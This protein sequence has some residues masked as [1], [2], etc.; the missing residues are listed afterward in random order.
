M[1]GRLIGWYEHVLLE[2]KSNE[3]NINNY[4][5]SMAS[6]H[7]YTY[8]LA[9]LGLCDVSSFILNEDREINGCVAKAGTQ[10]KQEQMS[11]RYTA[12]KYCFSISRPQGS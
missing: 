12:E 8:V 4:N 3:Q 11:I 6:Q 9:C 10:L 2:R 5:A 7:G 1:Y